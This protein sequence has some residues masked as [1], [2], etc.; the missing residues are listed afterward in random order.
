ITAFAVRKYRLTRRINATTGTIQGGTVVA[1]EGAVVTT[2]LDEST[3]ERVAEATGGRYFPALGAGA[4]L[5]L[6][7]EEVTGAEGREL[8]TREVTQFDEQFQI[9]LGFALILL[10]G[11]G[12]IPER[13]RR[14][15]VW[16]GRFS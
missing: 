7:V 14:E 9:F 16:A 11:E 2:R 5:D 4:D 1:E 15:E 3:L 6:L 8:E 13:R 10:F 12:W